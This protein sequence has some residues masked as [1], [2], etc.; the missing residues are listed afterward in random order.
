MIATK[1]L[2]YVNPIRALGLDYYVY[3]LMPDL[4]LAKIL[5]FFQ[6]TAK[7]AGANKNSPLPI[8]LL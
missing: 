2:I 5:T 3:G 7:K 8:L 4:D 6:Y 1:V